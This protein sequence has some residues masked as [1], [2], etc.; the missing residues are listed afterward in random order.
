M[1][2]S[3]D[4]ETW[5]DVDTAPVPS[6]IFKAGVLFIDRE[7]EERI[8]AP[9]SGIRPEL[10]ERAK[11]FAR[12]ALEVAINS[13]VGDRQL[14][15]PKSEWEGDWIDIRDA[16]NQADK[17]LSKLFKRIDTS[18][19]ASRRWVRFL[20]QSRFGRSTLGYAATT[21]RARRDAFILWSAKRLVKLLSADVERRQSEFV[22]ANKYSPGGDRHEFVFV[23]YEAWVFLTGKR[24][25]TNPDIG[26]NPFLRFVNAAWRDWKGDDASRVDSDTDSSWVNSDRQ[27]SF[28]Q[29]LNLARARLTD[30]QCELIRSEGPNWL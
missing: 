28:V 2:G 12:R 17:A 24:P 3:D 5:R 21:T 30:L 23:L 14:N 20:R 9:R 8:R 7:I 4:P 22:Q 11:A 27:I 19:P 1:S 26:R 13:A 29:S 25:G 18:G 10:R 6:K 16:A 15:P